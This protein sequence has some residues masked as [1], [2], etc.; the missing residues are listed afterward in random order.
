MPKTD[1][2]KS[3]RPTQDGASRFRAVVYLRVSTAKQ[4]E[5]ADSEEGYS[6]PAQREACYRR[7]EQLGA[8]VIEEYLDRGES[9]KTVDRPQFQRMFTRI[10]E[11][12]DVD[13]V[14]LDKVDRFARNR[15]D[16]ANLM[17]EMKAAGAQLISVKENID[18]T[19]A[20]ELLH[21]I[22]AG[23][24]EFYSRNLG[25]EAIKGMTQKAKLGGTPGR[26]P[27]G[28]LNV[29]KR[30]EGREVRAIEVDPER[31]PL[32][33]WAFEQYATGKWAMTTLTEALADRGLTTTGSAN[34]ESRPIYRSRVNAMLANRYYCGFVTFRGEEYEGRHEPLISVELFTKVQQVMRSHDTAGVRTRSHNHHLKGLLFC[35]ACGGRLCLT[36]AKG[37]YLYF[38]CLGRRDGCDQR[39]VAADEIEQ[40]VGALYGRM[41]MDVA[42]LQTAEDAFKQEM[43]EQH[44]TAAPRI[45]EAKR[46]LTQL[47]LQ[48]RRVARGVVDGSIPS[49][50][51]R[52]EQGRIAREMATASRA[53]TLAE[54]SAHDFERPFRLVLELIG[55]CEEIYERGDSTVRRLLNQ[56]FFEQIYIRH[57]EVTD[58]EL[59]EPWNTLEARFGGELIPVETFSPGGRSSNKSTMAAP[60]GFEPVSPP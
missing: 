41:K 55:R 24:A 54:Q 51:A 58:A 15:R 35:E 50:L 12:R 9:A 40:R 6:L 60:T 20:G 38:F 28:Y 30:I 2:A 33:K 4:A 39:Y 47:D 44:R 21:A 1:L 43:D 10:R 31:A 42:A 18:E 26:A 19:P 45:D 53:A 23:I 49:D 37:K 11:Q 57:G 34:R 17:F 36:N 25:T 46:Q 29:A 13:Y 27:I 48:R 16:D 22:M 52:E 56:A 14:I 3:P 5:K 7:A 59:L 32:V 8:D